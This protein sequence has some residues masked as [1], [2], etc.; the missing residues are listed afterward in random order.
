LGLV[1]SCLVLSCLVSCLVLSCP[2]LPCDRLVC[3]Y[4]VLPCGVVLYWLVLVLLIWFS[5]VFCSVL[6]CVVFSCNCSSGRSCVVLPRLDKPQHLVVFL[7]CLA[8]LP[9]LCR[10]LVGRCP[11]NELD[12]SGICACLPHWWGD[13]C[14]KTDY[15]A[16]LEANRELY[17]Y[18]DPQP[19]ILNVVGQFF[20]GRS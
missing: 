18:K 19:P 16:S 5:F 20:L 11:L 17:I 15:D 14:Q 6:A 1:L 4:L 7:N 2:V 13:N 8:C 9:P 3:F 12:A 10:C